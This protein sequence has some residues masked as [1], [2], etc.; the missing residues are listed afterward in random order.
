MTNEEIL[1]AILRGEP[2][3]SADV[4]REAAKVGPALVALIKNVRLWHT[5]EAGMW[6]VLHSIR[7]LSGLHLKEATP[8]LIDAIFLAYSTRHEEALE[9][10]PVALAQAG[11]GALNPLISIVED[12]TLDGTIRSVAASALEGLAVLHLD[13][14]DEVLASLRKIIAAPEESAALRGHAITIVAHFRLPEDSRLIKS[15]TRAMPMMS[16]LETDDIDEYF[17]RGEDPETWNAYRASLLEYY[18]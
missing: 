6:A 8:A 2:Q 1:K 18:Q 13:T 7:L 5:E 16:G 15:T 4:V 11:P 10:L 12:R 14:R 9:D 3:L 17:E